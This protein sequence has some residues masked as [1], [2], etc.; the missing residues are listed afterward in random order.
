MMGDKILQ[1]MKQLESEVQSS[2]TPS[3]IEATSTV[4]STVHQ[5]HIDTNYKMNGGPAQELQ[6]VT[7][8]AL[9]NSDSFAS[10]YTDFLES[11]DLR[12]PSGNDTMPSLSLDHH[13]DM[14]NPSL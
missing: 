4:S 13:A 12:K 9:L 14:N 10:V 3:S 7:F 8:E 5:D 11:L 6:D 1:K 2:A